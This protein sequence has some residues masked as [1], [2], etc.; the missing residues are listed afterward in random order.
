MVDIL[1]SR[2]YTLELSGILCSLLRA[3][4]GSN[5]FGRDRDQLFF[6]VSP[7]LKDSVILVSHPSILKSLKLYV[8][9][10]YLNE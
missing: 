3:K 1:G 6:A 8:G 2:P 10:A 4:T 7:C 9:C 5:W